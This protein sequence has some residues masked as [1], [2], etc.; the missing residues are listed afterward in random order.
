MALDLLNLAVSFAVG[1]VGAGLTGALIK[2]RFDTELEVWRSQR[3]WK[4]ESVTQLLAPI[5]AQLRRGGDAFQRWEARNAYVETQVIRASN[6]A[7]R[8]LLLSKAHLVPPSLREDAEALVTHYDVWLEEF[9]R[10]RSTTANATDSPGYVF[11][12]PKGYPFPKEAD[13]HFRKTFEEYWRDL[14]ADQF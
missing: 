2:K 4:Q 9:E 1:T 13:Q 12:G 8:D 14:Y 5:Y 7:I 10:V 11:V 3:G 6:L